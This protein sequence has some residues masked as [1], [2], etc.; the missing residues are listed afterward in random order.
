MNVRKVEEKS[1]KTA[2]T[3]ERR[4]RKTQLII[5]IIW[6][7]DSVRV[8]NATHDIHGVYIYTSGAKLRTRYVQ[9][10]EMVPNKGR[11][12]TGKLNTQTNGKKEHTHETDERNEEWKK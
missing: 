9:T 10:N 7:Y 11:Q 8:I 3:T 4:E 12:R 2:Q 6:L 5:I 1:L